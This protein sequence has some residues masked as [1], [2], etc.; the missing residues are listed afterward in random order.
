MREGQNAI[1]VSHHGQTIRG[2]VYLP[3][4][5]RRVP[6]VLLLH[7]FTGS[8]T[9]AG[10]VW[11]RLARELTKHG[12]A[13]VT[14]DFLNSG[15]SDGSFDQALVSGEIAD[16][17]HMAQWTSGQPFA[18][19]SRIGVIGFSLGGLVAAC[20]DARMAGFAAMA[21]IAPTTVK[22]LC[23]YET[24]PAT[25]SRSEP[26]TVGTQVLHSRFFDDLRQ[27]DPIA[28]ITRHSARPT[29]LVQGTADSAVAPNISDEYVQAM[30]RV[31]TPLAVKMVPGA[32]HSFTKPALRQQMIDHV[33]DW[34]AQTLG[35]DDANRISAL[36]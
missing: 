6:T 14:F 10:F 8:R 18:D 13:A 34:L 29:L 24:P 26:L 7:G 32:D 28:D 1:E 12:I 15:E 5:T 4:S 27:L 19:R 3:E 35:P 36:R 31:G 2:M 17:V 21:L 30:R 16:A 33:S 11:I 20:A 25:G 22:N 9:E 23:R